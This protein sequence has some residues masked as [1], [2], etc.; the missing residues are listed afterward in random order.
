MDDK[1]QL[2][3]AALQQRIGEL[4]TSYESQVAYLRAEITLLIKEKESKVEAVQE[5]EQHINDI[6]SN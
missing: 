3:I 1:A 4:T 5:Y 2:I 6:I